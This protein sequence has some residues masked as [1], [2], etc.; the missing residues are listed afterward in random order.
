MTFL[1]KKATWAE[2]GVSFD[3]SGTYIFRT[4]LKN[5]FIHLKKSCNAH[6]ILN[7]EDIIAQLTTKFSIRINDHEPTEFEGN[8]KELKI[9]FKDN[10]VNSLSRKTMNTVNV[11]KKDEVYNPTKKFEP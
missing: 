4:I 8:K 1:L 2:R 6:E 5:I 3:V 11:M 7:Q 9:D 10:K